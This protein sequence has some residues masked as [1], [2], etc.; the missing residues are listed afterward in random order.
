MYINDDTNSIYNTALGAF[1]TGIITQ[2]TFLATIFI[3]DIA[4]TIQKDGMVE[5]AALKLAKNNHGII[6]ENELALNAN[7]T[8]KESREYLNKLTVNG[9]IE[10]C[11]EKSGNIIYVFREFLNE[12]LLTERV[13]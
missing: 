4:R 11:V 6:T 13:K 12:K 8:I 3:K 10:M 7:I 1:V 9:Q 5:H 2:S